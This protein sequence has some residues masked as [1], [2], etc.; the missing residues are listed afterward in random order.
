MERAHHISFSSHFSQFSRKWVFYSIDIGTV[1][2]KNWITNNSECSSAYFTCSAENSK[3][4]WEEESV[5]RWLFFALRV[6]TILGQAFQS[7]EIIICYWNVLHI[8]DSMIKYVEFRCAVYCK[9]RIAEQRI[10]NL[11][12]MTSFFRCGFL[13]RCTN[14]RCVENVI[15]IRFTALHTLYNTNRMKCIESHIASRNTN[16]N[17]LFFSYMGE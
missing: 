2:K 16:K 17:T 8:S 3:S 6:F 15:L 14:Q 4:V 10:L 9:G 12:W 7:F 11:E 1:A 5:Q 13:L